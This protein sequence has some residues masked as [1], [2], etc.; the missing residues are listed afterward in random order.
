[1]N[2][3]HR[4]PD[5]GTAL[6]RWLVLILILAG[7][8]GFVLIRVWKSLPQIAI[9]EIGRLTGCQVYAESIEFKFNGSALIDGL[10]I[11]SYQEQRYDTTLLKAKTVYA[12]FSIG[13]L[14]LL[15]PRL[16]E[17]H[18]DNFDFNAQYDLDAGRWNLAA[19]R[20][21]VRKSGVGKMPFIVLDN[22]T[23][24]YS[25][26][27]KGRPTVLFAVPID[28]KFR[29]ANKILGGYSFDITT[30]EKADAGLYTRGISPKQGRSRLVGSWLP[31]RITV[32]GG[33][34][35]AG[36]PAFESA[37]V[38]DT[39]N[40][41]LNYDRKNNFLLKLTIKD[42]SCLREQGQPDQDGFASSR[43]ANAF[44]G[45]ALLSALQ[46][47][48]GKYNPA[49]T[50]NLD[51]EASGNFNQLSESTVNG[52]VFCR[53]ASICDYKFPYSI[54]HLTGQVDFTENSAVL[55]DLSGRHGNVAIVFTGWIK[56]FGPNQRY[57][58][59]MTSSNMALDD[60]LYE[61]L[62][63]K[64]KEL[65][66][67]FSPSGLAAIDYRFSRHSEMDTQK[68]LEVQLH[69]VEAAYKRFSYPL[70]DLKGKL[71]FESD[72][73]TLSDIV[74]QANGGRI[75]FNGKV[76]ECNIDQPIY[77]LS[78][79]A[80]DVP[81]DPMFARMLPA[82]QG[83]LY[84]HFDV[85]GLA[86]AD[87]AVFTPREDSTSESSKAGQVPPGSLAESRQ[88]SFTANVTVKQATLRVSKSGLIISNISAKVNLTPDSTS[89][90]NF[91]G[92]YGQS[93]VSLVGGIWLADKLQ[94]PRF[95]MA[96]DAQQA[97]LSDA[98]IGLLPEQM[99]KVVSDMQPSGKVNIKANLRKTSRPS[100][101]P[102]A[103]QS[104]YNILV[105]CLGNS[106]N[107]KQFSYPLKDVTGRLT[108]TNNKV[109][110]DDVVA[111]PDGGVQE[112]T[113]G[114]SLKV[115]GQITLADK[116]FSNGVFQLSAR[117]ILFGEHLVCALPAGAVS[118][119]QV[120]S[121]AGRFDLDLENV[122]IF[123]TDDG[124]KYI[125]FAATAGFKACSF[126]V[127]GARAELNAVLKTKGLYKTGSGL[128]NGRISILA[129]SLIIKDKAIT[130]LRA[131][132][133]YDPLLWNWLADNLVADCYGGRLTGK[134][135]LKPA[136]GAWEYM[137]QT[138][139]DD[140]DL[141]QFLSGE[142]PAGNAK[143]SHANSS[144][145]GGASGTMSGSLGIAAQ[146]GDNS[147]RLGRCRWAIKDMQVGK[148]SPLAKLLYVLNLTEPKDFAFEQMIVDSYIR[149]DRLLFNVFDLSGETVAFHGSGSMSLKDAGINLSLTARGR[150]LAGA[151]PTFLGSLTEGLGRAVVRIEVT[152]NVQDP[153]VETKTLPVVEDSLKILG[154]PRS[155]G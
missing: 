28:V 71:Y 25:K 67:A 124:E 70:K 2:I 143:T 89:I 151:E 105:E 135:E 30:A 144:T 46:D 14:L 68:S 128:S 91:T 23:L 131:D 21:D 66:A 127:S 80:R 98:L 119:Y 146:I 19:L 136:A 11:K 53:D 5:T 26:I 34:S 112:S 100:A 139:F 99:A 111:A 88:V 101:G 154:T 43:P 59:R 122:K 116:T 44:N 9:E 132:V 60:D 93:T 123:K 152:G 130:N 115:N 32:S 77:N 37:W 107:F 54:E 153:K 69:G 90:K 10:V 97:Q 63:Q 8:F 50:V 1:M 55:N 42:L 17:I 108:I 13:S 110:I 12:R 140:I 22:G 120:L 86:D 142:E 145:E 35:S 7:V 40:A 41:A 62:G 85:T 52:K 36:I 126:N 45:P 141:K 75:T 58:I 78:I 72:S 103:N 48:F 137:L 33:I 148:L 24:Q 129:G 79:K 20:F 149:S 138:V 87:I 47:F 81:F 94:L 117:D 109:T 16:K 3:E 39:L 121:P 56:D 92:Y 102:E 49:G 29:P 147:S 61:A 134:L 64:Y 84:R 31:G 65:W 133:N 74:S 125:D 15:M 106:I 155:G 104:D 118:I 57:Q 83:D 51:I 114:S 76:T 95:Y 38:I 113:N 18:I 82:E 4:T 150:R 96:L 73:I 27:S 6:L